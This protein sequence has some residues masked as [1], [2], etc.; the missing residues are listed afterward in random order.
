MII[1]I[2]VIIIII[3]IV[4]IIILTTTT[5]TMTPKK[6]PLKK[7]STK[8]KILTDPGIFGYLSSTPPPKKKKKLHHPS[9][10]RSANPALPD[11]GNLTPNATPKP[12]EVRPYQEMIF[13]DQMMG[14]IIP[15]RKAGYTLE[16]TYKSPMKRK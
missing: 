5:T 6:S 15:A 13:W 11:H 7:I 10:K 14:F 2:I 9:T 12:S 4:I 1:I 16:I 8:R 3:I